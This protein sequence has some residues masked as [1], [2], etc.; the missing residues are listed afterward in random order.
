MN[1]SFINV[2]FLILVVLSMPLILFS[3]VG[4]QEIPES[5]KVYVEGIVVEG[6]V[7]GFWL[8]DENGIKIRFYAKDNVEYD[9]LDFHA[10]YGDRVGVTYYMVIKKGEDTHK[11][12]KVVLLSKNPRRIE[13]QSRVVDGIIRIAGMFRHMVYLPEY[14]L[15]IPFNKSG[16]VKY[17]PTGWKPKEG[18]KVLI[19]FDQDSGRFVRNLIFDHMT[20]YYENDAI[21]DKTENG[22]ITGIFTHRNVHKV[23]DRFAF[24]LKNGNTWTMYAG[25]ETKLVPKDLQVNLGG[26]YKIK[27]YRKLMNDQSIRYVAAM[28]E[29]QK[30]SVPAEPMYGVNVNSNEPWTGTWKVTGSPWGNFVL[31]LKQSGSEV[32]SIQGSERNWKAK[33]KGDRLTGWYLYIYR[34]NI[35]VKIS[36]DFTSFQGKVFIKSESHKIKGERQE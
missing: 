16:A 3:C 21:K 36:D 34:T 24:K 22:V 18:D 1:R 33:A 28:I 26:S 10:Y 17:T 25:G 5:E 11:A 8:K 30:G 23:P 7:N 15:T 20:S 4:P 13:F 19:H 31:K 6:G 14:D 27:Y 12:L 9:P 32:K 35:D 2:L 29:G